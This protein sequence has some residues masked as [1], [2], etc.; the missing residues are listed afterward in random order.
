MRRAMLEQL[1]AMRQSGRP[2]IR[3][4]DVESGNENLIDPAT[5][6]SPLG[7]AAARALME[8]ASQRVTVD[9]RNWFLTV[10]NTPWE[11]VIIGAV[12]IAQALAKLGA[13]MGYRVRV[14]DPRGAYAAPE[15]FSGV[16]VIQEWPEDA[17]AAEPLTARSALI[18]LSHD[19]KLDDPALVA[20]L[21]SPA[22]YI[23][24]LGSVRTHASRLVRLSALGFTQSELARI[25]GPVGLG[26]GARSPGEIAL[27]ILAQLVQLRRGAAPL[28]IGGVILAAGLSRRMGRNKLLAELNGKPLLRHAGEAA[29]ASRLDPVIVVTGHEEAN[30]R[31]ALSGL[32]VGFIH[33]PRFAEG[34]SSSLQAGVRALPGDCDGALVLLGDMPG[35]TPE[36]IDRTVAAFDPAQGRA[37]CVAA[38]GGKR[39]HPVLWGRQFFG[40]IE[41]LG[42]DAGAQVLMARHA[43]QIGEV[44]AMDDAPFSDIDTP[45]ALAAW[46]TNV[47]DVEKL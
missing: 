43:A 41:N 9:G 6:I 33:N 4:L 10:Y 20:G 25:H 5:D 21:R 2:V 44:E 26:I 11:L 13:A 37:I 16:R 36:L 35:I 47:L 8:D 14:I 40:E 3:A 42:G 31:K 46:S 27:A 17:L 19:I 28:R 34:L 15:R 12:H 7:R 22:G 18:A 30:I 24:A 23:G 38:R 45:E 32:N 1:L 29:L 39:G